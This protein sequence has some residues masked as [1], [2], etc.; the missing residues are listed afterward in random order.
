VN[1]ECVSVFATRIDLRDWQG[2][3]CS[4]DDFTGGTTS[5][6][7]AAFNTLMP[8]SMA[9]KLIA[10][11][12]ISQ[13]SEKLSPFRQ[14]FLKVFNAE[15]DKKVWWKIFQAGLFLDLDS[16]YPCTSYRVHDMFF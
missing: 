5:G 9:E 13:N 11:R 4:V 8:V 2:H 14:S 15:T 6:A 12:S 16:A 10:K 7:V 1:I 3:F